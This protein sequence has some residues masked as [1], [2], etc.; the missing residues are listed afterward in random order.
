MDSLT[1]IALGAACGEAVA[2]RRVGG[3]AALWGGAA[4]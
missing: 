4:G 1:Q 2:G 3:R